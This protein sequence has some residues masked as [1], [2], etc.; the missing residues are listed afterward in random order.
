MIQRN[1]VGKMHGNEGL[2]GVS[3]VS[4]C[5]LAFFFF[6]LSLQEFLR[7][8]KVQNHLCNSQYQHRQFWFVSDTE[9]DFTSLCSWFINKVPVY[10]LCEF[11]CDSSPLEFHSIVSFVRRLP[12]S[13]MYGPLN[14]RYRKFLLT[15]KSN[16]TSCLDLLFYHSVGFL[17]LL[18]QGLAGLL[19]VLLEATTN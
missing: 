19:T 13:A 1:H 3:T 2:K 15:Y 4:P 16:N 10:D 7:W 9:R 14:K 5:A 17:R 11:T 8:R 12:W 6:F 18:Y